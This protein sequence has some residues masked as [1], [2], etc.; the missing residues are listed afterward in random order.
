MQSPQSE[1]TPRRLT[2]R[3]ALELDFFLLLFLQ[4]DPALKINELIEDLKSGVVLL[5][6]LEVLSGCKLQG[7]RG[8]ILKRPHFL[9][10]CN[11]ALEFLRTRKVRPKHLPYILKFIYSEKATKFWEIFS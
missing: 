7:E 10:N 3:I 1:S 8:R 9:S 4:R 6:L 2:L 11:T 5:T